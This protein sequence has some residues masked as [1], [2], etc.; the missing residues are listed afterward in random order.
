MSERAGGG[1]SV[2]PA[3]EAPREESDNAFTPILRAV[4]ASVPAV[5]VVA[6]VD[7]EGECIDYVSTIDTYDAK[8]SAA[9]LFVLMDA[10]RRS[11]T[12][13]GLDPAVTLEIVGSERELWGRRVSDEYVIAVVVALGFDR[14]QLRAALARAAAEFRDEVELDTP[15]WE[16]EVDPLQVH[17]RRSPNWTYAPDFFRQDGNRIEIAD[18]LGRWTE[19]VPGHAEELVCFRVRTGDGREV[20]LVHDPDL[21]DWR[22]R[23]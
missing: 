7:L 8:V 21:E 4:R 13:L 3:G 5:L 23:G 19:A 15:A 22:V 20:T 9:H 1:G 2:R 16:P 6:F 17:V 11:R 12:K 18:V 10:L 14:V